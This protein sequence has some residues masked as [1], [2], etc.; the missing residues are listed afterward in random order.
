MQ[1]STFYIVYNTHFLLCNQCHF[2]PDKLIELVNSKQTLQMKCWIKLYWLHNSIHPFSCVTYKTISLSFTAVIQIISRGQ[3]RP[4]VG[5]V[6][7]LL[8]N[9][10]T[11]MSACISCHG[12][13]PHRKINITIS[14][15]YSYSVHFKEENKTLIIPNVHCDV[16]KTLSALCPISVHM[17]L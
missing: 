13:A 9:K 17:V 4:M 1:V 11:K 10:L 14:P 15:N 8:S 12:Y 7:Y 3:W 5:E 16:I 2:S 6:N